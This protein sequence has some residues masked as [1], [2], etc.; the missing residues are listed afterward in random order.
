[1]EDAMPD[2]RDGYARPP[3]LWPDWATAFEKS[4]GKAPRRTLTRADAMRRN[5]KG[6]R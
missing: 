1:M 6:P 3:D 4:I 5:L 2:Y